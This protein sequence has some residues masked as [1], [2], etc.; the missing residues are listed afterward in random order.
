MVIVRQPRISKQQMNVYHLW[1][2]AE[3]AY[4]VARHWLWYMPRMKL[5]LQGH[6]VAVST[7]FIPS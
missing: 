5:W 4:R 2:L 6:Q 3:I 7:L 1:L